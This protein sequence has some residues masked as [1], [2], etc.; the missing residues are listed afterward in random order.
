MKYADYHVFIFKGN[1]G[2]PKKKKNY[3]P[4]KHLQYWFVLAW[5]ANIDTATMAPA[6]AQQITQA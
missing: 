2:W 3:Q 1:M 5:W 6:N 4:R